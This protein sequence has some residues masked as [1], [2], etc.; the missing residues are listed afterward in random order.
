M[1][2][3]SVLFLSGKSIQDNFFFFSSGWKIK[4]WKNQC[5]PQFHGCLIGESLRRLLR[6]SDV[7]VCLAVS[8]HISAATQAWGCTQSEPTPTLCCTGSRVS[9]NFLLYM[10]TIKLFDFWRKGFTKG[11]ETHHVMR[12]RHGPAIKAGCLS[13]QSVELWP[14]PP[15]ANPCWNSLCFL[16]PLWFSL[17]L[18]ELDVGA[19]SEAAALL[20]GTRD[21][22]SFR[23]VNS[24][25]PFKSPVKTLDVASIQPGCSFTQAHFHRWVLHA[26]SALSS[27][28]PLLLD[29]HKI[30]EQQT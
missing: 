12:A 15:V 19:M 5:P 20:V 7:S 18:S 28:S 14:P 21:F 6:V 27:N 26:V 23:A 10:S 13:G 24:D 11:L 29:L 9:S 3:F 8:N 25:M 22:S 1:T 4:S 30:K 16:S 2:V 17:L